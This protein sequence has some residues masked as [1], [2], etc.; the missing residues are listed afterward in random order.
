MTDEGSV[1]NKGSVATVAKRGCFKWCI[2]VQ[3]ECMNAIWSVD[4]ILIIV[5]VW[6]GY[7]KGSALDI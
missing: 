2:T 1:T 5:L 7:L 6:V 3:V 4:M